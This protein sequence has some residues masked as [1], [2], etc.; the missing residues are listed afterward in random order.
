MRGPS[1]FL[2]VWYDLPAYFAGKN[3]TCCCYWEIGTHTP[4][5]DQHTLAW[6]PACSSMKTSMLLHG[7]QHAPAWQPACSCMATSKLL[8]W[9]QHAQYPLKWMSYVVRL[10]SSQD[11]FTGGLSDQ[12]ILTRTHRPAIVQYPLTEHALRLLLQDPLTGFMS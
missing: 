2:N 10:V 4:P 12:F 8:H 3:S 9:S 5:L 11:P 6:K 7:N 1:I